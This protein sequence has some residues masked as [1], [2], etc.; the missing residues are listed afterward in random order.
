MHPRERARE[1]RAIPITPNVQQDIGNELNSALELLQ[2]RHGLTADQMVYAT[3]AFTWGI[4]KRAMWSATRLAEYAL[5]SWL[6]MDE[7]A[8]ADAHGLIAPHRLRT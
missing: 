6:K 3:V 4:S 1:Q 7:N 2:Q 8:A 5:R